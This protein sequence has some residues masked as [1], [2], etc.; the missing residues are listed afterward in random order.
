MLT[1]ARFPARVDPQGELLRLDNQDRSKWDAQLIGEGLQH[2]VAAARGDELTE[3]HLQAGIAAIHCTAADAKATD[4]P[5]ILRH[6]DALYALKPSPIVALNRAVAVAQVHGPQAGLKELATMPQRE[7][8]AQNHVLPAVEG[9]FYWRLKDHRAAA[10]SFRRAL[11][12]SQGGPEQA[13]LARRL[14]RAE[15]LSGPR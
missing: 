13:L 8:L 9:E 14:E 11:R 10:E 2:L 1:A 12:L 6:Y 7:R 4:W 3:Y 5:R 15:D